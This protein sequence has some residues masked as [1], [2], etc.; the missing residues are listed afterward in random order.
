MG[1]F[2]LRGQGGRRTGSVAEVSAMGYL[3]REP[4]FATKNWWRRTD[5]DERRL[6]HQR[7]KGRWHPPKTRQKAAR[8]RQRKGD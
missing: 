2:R 4:H 8:K 3:V 5:K 6:K 1:V 7:P